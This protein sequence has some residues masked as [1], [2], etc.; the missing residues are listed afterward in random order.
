MGS[1]LKG[2][3]GKTKDIFEREFCGDIFEL[4]VV[5]LKGVNGAAVLKDGYEIPSVHF[6]ACVD[7]DTNELFD[8]E[9][10]IEWLVSPEEKDEKGWGYAFEPLKIY[11]IKCRKRP[12]IDLYPYMSE[13][14]NNC[15]RILEYYGEDKTDDRLE[16]LIKEYS[17]PVVIKDTIGEFTLN[18]AFSWFEGR[19]E[20]SSGDLRVMFYADKNMKMPPSSFA[21]LKKFAEDIESMDKKMREFIVEELWETAIDWAES[22]EEANDLTKDYFY[23][24]LYPGELLIVEEGDLT[25]YYGDDKDIF[26]GHS[27]E[28]IVDSKGDVKGADLVG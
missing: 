2:P 3:Y 25:V 18:R 7:L 8:F 14:T 4:L 24:S 5:T 13:V 12:P 28:V 26:A 16:A 9:G 19:I 11:H 20:F 6:V 27:I 1:L 10:R 15:Y 17:K 23:D 21:Y 22:E